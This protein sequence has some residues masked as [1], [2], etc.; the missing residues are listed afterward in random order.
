MS[1]EMID[2]TTCN[3][4]V[5]GHGSPVDSFLRRR[6]LPAL[7]LT[8]LFLL[9]ALIV[10]SS[11]TSL[12]NGSE[13]ESTA[14]RSSSLAGPPHTE[15]IKGYGIPAEYLIVPSD[16]FPRGI[17]AVA[18][19]LDYH[20]HPKKQYPLVIA[21]GGAGECIRPPRDGALAWI[22]YYK[23][24]DAVHALRR[25]RLTKEDF[26]GFVTG[27]QLAAFNRSLEKRPYRGVI[28]A[29]PYSPPLTV[30]KHLESPSYEAFIMK[31]LLP[32]LLARYRVAKGRVGVDGVSMGG[33]RSMYYGLKYPRVFCSIGSLQG[34]FGPFRSVYRDLAARNAGLLQKRSIQLVT[35][36]GDPMAP[37][38]MEMHRLLSK[39]SIPHVFSVMTGPHDYIFNQGPGC[40]ALLTFHNAARTCP[41]L[42]PM[43]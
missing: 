3:D 26:R 1:S 13:N 9:S 40:I 37:D 22:D 30:G 20:S 28:V 33:A 17:T 21:F 11:C 19:P 6:K 38:V 18:L 35:S 31:D 25:N 27:P 8:A 10:P 39:W 16:H 43:R 23:L 36:D 15:P 2:L 5:S 41:D 4:N 34:A 7:F 42:R 14:S 12:G 32:E 24:G 29:C